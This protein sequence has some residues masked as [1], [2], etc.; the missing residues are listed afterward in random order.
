MQLRDFFCYRCDGNKSQ[1]FTACFAFAAT[2]VRSSTHP[3]AA[4]VGVGLLC[5][6]MNGATQETRM[7]AVNS[8]RVGHLEILTGWKEIANYLRK[9][10]RSVQR[11]ERELGLP[12]RRP[13]GKSTVF[14]TKAEM[15]AWVDASPVRQELRLSVRAVNDPAKWMRFKQQMEEMARLQQETSQLRSEVVASRKALSATT[16]LLRKSLRVAFAEDDQASSMRHGGGDVLSFDPNGKV[17]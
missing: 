2:M 9:G 1:I 8:K 13:A 3:S 4:P 10:V 7:S 17:N 5:N 12:I 11:Y 14:A 15:D 6:L 16:K